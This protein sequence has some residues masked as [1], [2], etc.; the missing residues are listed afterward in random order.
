MA[1]ALKPFDESREDKHRKVAK[2]KEILDRGAGSEPEV[3]IVRYGLG[4]A[5]YTAAEA[6]LI[7][8]LMTFPIVPRRD[9]EARVPL[10]RQAQLT[11]A[12]RES[13]RG[14]G[15]TLLRTLV[16]EHAAPSLATSVPLLLITLNG[17]QDIPEGEEMADGRLR[18]WAGWDDKWL[19]S[20]VREKSFQEIGESVSGWWR[21]DLDRVARCGIEHVAA[22]HRGVT[23]ALFK[24]DPTSWKDRKDD[25][26]DETGIP[27]T[28]RAF[29]FQVVNSEDLFDNVVG[30]HGHRVPARTRGDQSSV[31]YWPRP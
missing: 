4:Q 16:D 10:G 12:R 17:S 1:E 5:E 18:Y 22:V 6:A 15:I 13:A 31:H 27:V 24:I 26:E 30:P 2:I 28:R 7:D 25:P 11:N 19:V 23:R 29:R 3:W 21:I 8:L 20:S 14:H 9:G